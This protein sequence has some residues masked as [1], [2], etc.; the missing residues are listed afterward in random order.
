MALVTQGRVLKFTGRNR[1]EAKR[2]AL[3]FWYTH[4]DVLRES[5]QDFVKKCS[6]S[7]DQKVITYHPQPP[8]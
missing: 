2:K 3:R 4:R 7:P 6:L 8:R 5:M 1:F